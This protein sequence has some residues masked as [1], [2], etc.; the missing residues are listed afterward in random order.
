MRHAEL[1]A[2]QR[3]LRAGFPEG[4][5]LRVH[6][7]L[8]W[9]GRAEAEADDGDVRFILLWIGFNAAYAGDVAQ[10]VATAQQG[11]RAAFGAFFDALLALDATK[12]IYNTIWQRFG[13]EIRLLL[14]NRHVFAPFWQHHN[15]VAGF[16]DWGTRLERARATTA[17]ALRQ[18]D[19]AT[20]LS[21]LFDRLYVLRGQLVHGGATWGGE[22]NRPQVRDGAAV[23]GTLLPIFVDL[24][25]DHPERDWPM[26]HYPVV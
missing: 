1:K 7:A 19:T 15:G 10:E 3:R 14:E 8:S 4:L 23:L 18:Q 16:E 13:E 21:I 5:N 17:F 2:K 6:R 26:P 25:M 11:E 22:V 20:I 12:R 24:M 9:L